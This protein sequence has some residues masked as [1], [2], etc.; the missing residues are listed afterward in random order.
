ML[1]VGTQAPGFE[2]V[3]Q[4]GD[5]VSLTD[6]RGRRVV[7]YFYPKAS[8]PGC[9]TEAQGFRDNYA[10]FG[11]LDVAVLGVSADPVE[12]ILAFAEAQDLPFALLSDPDGSVATAY[13]SYGEREIRGETWEIPFRNTYVI[14]DEGAIEAAYEGVSPDEHPAKILADLD[15]R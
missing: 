11:E 7:L 6:F 15:D 5:T 1:D 10:G 14:D 8:T 4:H 12:D 2:L 9:T 3:D 13:E